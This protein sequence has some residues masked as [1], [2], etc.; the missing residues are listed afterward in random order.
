MKLSLSNRRDEAD[1]SS[2]DMSYLRRVS[3][4]QTKMSQ[5]SVTF[6]SLSNISLFSFCVFCRNL[7]FQ[8]VGTYKDAV[9]E[10]EKRPI[11]VI[12]G[13]AAA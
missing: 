4:V 12:A 6:P 8:S 5:F 3:R 9:G 10:Q 2:F 7:I 11:S 1:V 13:K